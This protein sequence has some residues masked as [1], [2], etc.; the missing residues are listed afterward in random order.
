M[1]KEIGTSEIIDTWAASG[2]SAEPELAKKNIGWQSGERPPFQWM[3][4]LFN[5]IQQKINH[6]FKWGIPL[7]NTANAYEVNAIVAHEGVVYVAVNANAASEPPSADWRNFIV[8]KKNTLDATT[9]PT[10]NDDSADGYSIGS[11]WYN[12]TADEAFEAFDVTVGAALWIK[13]TLTIDE[14]GSAAFQNTSAFATAAQGAL[15]DSALQTLPVGSIINTVKVDYTANA[16]LTVAIPL[17]NSI[18]Q[19]TEGTQIISTTY[20]MKNSANKLRVRFLGH[21]ASGTYSIAALFR[22]A[23]ANAIGVGVATHANNTYYQTL[24]IPD[25]EFLPAAASVDLKVRVGANAGTMRLNGAIAAGLFGGIMVSTMV[26]EEI[27]V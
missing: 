17:D 10:V 11:K 5:V 25:I 23:I 26:I 15:A 18:P 2:A 3:N 4:W 20:T 21:S 13:T 16:D 24:A 19:N 14:L 1:T 7:W 22:D 12:Q 6:I 8:E 27:K 9:N